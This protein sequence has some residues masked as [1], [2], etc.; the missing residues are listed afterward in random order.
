MKITFPHLGNT[1]ITVKAMLE[2]LG[3]ECIVPPFNNKKALELG[4]RHVSEMSC[5]P[6][7]INIGNYIQAYEMG[8]DT[9]LMAGGCGPCRFGYYCEM[10]REILRDAGYD[11]EI[12]TL[13]FN[14]GNVKEL[15][16]RL[17]RIVGTAGLL[18]IPYVIGQVVKTA[19][20]V[21]E[22]ELL[23]FKKRSREQK[24]GCV[25]SIYRS[26][27][28]NALKSFGFKGIAKLLE[29]TEE[30]LNAVEVN[31]QSNPLKVGVVGE[32]Y[33]GIEQF[34]SCNIQEKLGLMGVEVDRKVSVSNWIVEHI[35][36]KGLHLPRDMSYAEAAKPWL[37]TM[38]GGHAQETIGN[39]VL[40][41]QNNYD[42]VIQIFPFSCMPEIVAESLLP[43]IE[44][45]L[46]IPVLTLIIDEMTGEA[47]YMTRVEAFI[48]MLEKRRECKR[49]ES[50][51]L[52]SWN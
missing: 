27:R 29:E 36:K 23:T 38:I 1:Y 11:M 6:L 2:D 17:H 4:T 50:E 18:K 15:A 52:L 42:G 30:K 9:I 51:W 5:L 12:I 19:K 10:H 31:Q 24:A 46:G 14:G 26:F 45:E 20:R 8:A 34:A 25:D 44:S 43:S 41:A 7:K 35:L 32:I 37:G 28:T 3:I 40:Y 33:T 47:G 39:T 49:H 22:L 48:D 13:E 21:D 16:N